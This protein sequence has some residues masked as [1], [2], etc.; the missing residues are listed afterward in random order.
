[1]HGEKFTTSG[2][3]KGDPRSQESGYHNHLPSS[4]F[5]LWY[6]LRGA[7]SRMVFLKTLCFS[8]PSPVLIHRVP[9]KLC[10]CGARSTCALV[11]WSLLQ[12]NVHPETQ[13]R[14]NFTYTPTSHIISDICKNQFSL[15]SFSLSAKVAPGDAKHW[16][17]SR[18]LGDL[19]RN[20]GLHKLGPTHLSYSH[21]IRGEFYS[22]NQRAKRGYLIPNTYMCIWTYYITFPI[23]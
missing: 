22:W 21:L 19:T 11:F 17:S 6:Q 13:E 12:D 10:P 18:P 14:C 15:V 16:P 8:A 9:F 4:I 2:W 5:P 1:M 23:I 3:K 20:K 7:I